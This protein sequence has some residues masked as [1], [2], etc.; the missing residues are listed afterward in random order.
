MSTVCV[1]GENLTLYGQQKFQPCKQKFGSNVMLNVSYLEIFQA[2]A[3]LKQR[4]RQHSVDVNFGGDFAS[5]YCTIYSFCSYTNLHS[6]KIK[7][8]LLSSHLLQ[9]LIKRIKKKKRQL[10]ALLICTVRNSFWIT[11]IGRKHTSLMHYRRNT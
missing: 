9:D 2:H 3:V 10:S 8:S 5:P 4:V 6:R 11:S 7:R 1:N